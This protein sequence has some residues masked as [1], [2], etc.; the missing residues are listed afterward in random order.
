MWKL[1]KPSKFL[2]PRPGNIGL[3]SSRESLTT[4][5]EG[6]SLA[7]VCNPSRDVSIKTL[8]WRHPKSN[9]KF[10]SDYASKE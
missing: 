1:V 2:F 8:V 3:V 4:W 10:M 6:A 5:G 9:P 7:L